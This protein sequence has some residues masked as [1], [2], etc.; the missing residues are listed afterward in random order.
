MTEPIQDD[1]LVPMTRAALNAHLACI[2]DEDLSFVAELVDE[3]ERKNLITRE[4]AEQLRNA[5]A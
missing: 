5:A 4:T 3:L 1:N 2:D